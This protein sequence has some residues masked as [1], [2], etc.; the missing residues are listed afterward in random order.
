M[1]L[2]DEVLPT[3]DCASKL[4]F[5]HTAGPRTSLYVFAP[6]AAH[7]PQFGP[8][9]PL[10]HRQLVSRV[11]PAGERELPIYTNDWH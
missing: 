5:E 2:V 3:A 11:L 9:Y 10:L 4:Q 1:Q 7:V 6:H 8:E